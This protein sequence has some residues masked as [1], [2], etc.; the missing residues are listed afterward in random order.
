MAPAVRRMAS[1]QNKHMLLYP[2]SYGDL[3]GLEIYKQNLALSLRFQT[4]SSIPSIVDETKVRMLGTVVTEIQPALVIGL[5]STESVLY[6]FWKVSPGRDEEPI[7]SAHASN[8]VTFCIFSKPPRVSGSL[9]I[10]EKQLVP[11]LP[12]APWGSTSLAVR[13][14]RHA[15]RPPQLTENQ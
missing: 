7:P 9:S 6:I 11:A 5:Y 4:D 14:T 1:K 2:S 10:S 13:S 15:P 3:K 8:N 12:T